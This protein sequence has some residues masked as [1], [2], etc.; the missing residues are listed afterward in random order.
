MSACR[1][2][3]IIRALREHSP[4][5]SRVSL[6]FPFQGAVFALHGGSLTARL[7][8]VARLIPW[9]SRADA[10]VWAFADQEQNAK[11]ASR[12]PVA[13]GTDARCAG[14]SRYRLETRRA[15]G[16]GLV[17]S[18]RAFCILLHASALARYPALGVKLSCRFVAPRVGIERH[19]PRKS[20]GTKTGTYRCDGSSCQRGELLARQP[21]SV[22]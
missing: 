7:A 15:R 5:T 12:K 20:T 17:I 21:P 22:F 1:G 9:R 16:S 13:L 4:E 19:C 11:A 18:T 3:R 2:Q 6:P 14:R 10:R 8:T